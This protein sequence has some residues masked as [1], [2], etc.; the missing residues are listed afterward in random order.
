MAARTVCLLFLTS[1]LG[2]APVIRD[3]YPRGAQRGRTIRITV[4]GDGLL[5]GA[6]LRTSLPANISRLAP[7][8]DMAK[9]DSEL[10]FLVEIRKDAPLGFYPLRLVAA[11][12]ISNV[13]LFA[14]GDLPETEEIESQ[15]PK[16]L[17]GATRE[18]QPLEVPVVVNGDLAGADVDHYSFTAK[19][20]EKL[21][22][23]VEA[24]RAGSA[25]DPAIEIL[26]PAGRVIARNDDGIGADIDSRFE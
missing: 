21:V 22:F 7:P 2:A 10:P 17:N 18:A 5:A 23:E 16:A 25:I 4:R 8:R 12:G 24:R 6:Q 15:N 14:I 19:A 20:G 11:D 13:V 26:D 1:I 9:P 3:V